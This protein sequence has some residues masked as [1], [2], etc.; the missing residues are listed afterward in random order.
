VVDDAGNT[1]PS[2]AAITPFIEVTGAKYGEV[3]R[4]VSFTPGTDFNVFKN[5]SLSTLAGH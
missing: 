1:N 4:G 2:L 5:L 3:L